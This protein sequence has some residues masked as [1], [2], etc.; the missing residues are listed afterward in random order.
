VLASIIAAQD[1]AA[2]GGAPSPVL[3]D[4]MALWDFGQAGGSGGLADSWVDTSGNGFHATGSGASRPTLNANGTVSFVAGK[5]LSAHAIGN[6]AQPITLSLRMR[7]PGTTLTRFFGA[8]DGA[9]IYLDGSTIRLIAGGS[10]ANSGR[11][12]TPGEWFSLI[13]VYAG[14]ASIVT[15]ASGE[16]GSLNPGTVGLA[17]GAGISFNDASFY[18][19]GTWDCAFAALHAGAMSADNRALQM[20]YLETI[21]PA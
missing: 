18:G 2:G 13:V 11:A 5:K 19:G 10:D 21:Q 4:I 14:N 20:A 7:A 9:T 8:Q 1:A 3:T 12:Y 15:T 16:T 17:S 6:L